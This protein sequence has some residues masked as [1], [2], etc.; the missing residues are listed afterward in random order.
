[1]STS[2]IS[3]AD[4]M[5]GD[6]VRSAKALLGAKSFSDAVHRAQYDRASENALDF[7]QRKSSASAAVTGSDE[8]A[9]YL[10]GQGGAPVGFVESLKPRSLFFRFIPLCQQ[11]PLFQRLVAFTALPAAGP[12]AEGAWTPA[13]QGGLEAFELAPEKVGGVLIASRELATLSDPASFGLLRRKLQEVAVAAVDDRF[14]EIALDEIDPET[15]DPDDLLGDIEKLLETV[16]V[17]GGERLA[18]MA[19]ASMAR[20]LATTTTTTGARVFPL[21]GPTGG[22][23]LDVPCWVSDRL[24]PDMLI[25]ADGGGFIG[26]PGGIDLDR[27][28]SAALQLKTE[29]TEAPAELI[30]TFQQGLVAIKVLASFA[31]ERQKPNAVAAMTLPSE[32]S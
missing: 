25:L 13:G 28:T 6:F 1:M 15:A 12:V 26:N 5:A 14:L 21:M 16:V 19:G 17:T 23:L 22:S 24:D 30:S 11:F 3:A 10:A 18:F 31:I 7:L 9:G 32:G 8:W 29:P 27:S 20:A 2:N 4:R